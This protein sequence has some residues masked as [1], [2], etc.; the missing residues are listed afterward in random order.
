[1]PQPA[2][3]VSPRFPPPLKKLNCGEST[4]HQVFCQRLSTFPA[5]SNW[6]KFCC[7]SP[8]PESRLLAR[9]GHDMN[10]LICSRPLSCPFFSSNQVL[11]VGRFS[12]KSTRN[13]GHAVHHTSA[14]RASAQTP[15]VSPSHATSPSSTACKPAFAHFPISSAA[16]RARR[17]SAS[18][19]YDC[20][21]R[22]MRAHS[23]RVQASFLIR[24]HKTRRALRAGP[25][26][27]PGPSPIGSGRRLALQDARRNENAPTSLCVLLRKT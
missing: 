5:S 11:S 1:M 6:A 21:E 3:L 10:S 17:A 15:E 26:I 16:R 4:H 24:A 9:H 22:T 7:S 14:R 18:C 12:S 23:R 20:D 13:K 25:A 8:V 2:A 19:A 27:A